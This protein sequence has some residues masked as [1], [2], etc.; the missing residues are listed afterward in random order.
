MTSA[1]VQ[2]SPAPRVLAGALSAALL[3]HVALLAVMSPAL[4]R[5]VEGSA[6]VEPLARIAVVP[7]TETESAVQ[8]VS[9]PP[10][11]DERVPETASFADRFAR[12]VE[13]QTVNRDDVLVARAAPDRSVEAAAAGAAPSRPAAVLVPASR[14]LGGAPSSVQTPGALAPAA[15]E[16]GPREAEPGQTGA[17]AEAAARRPLLALGE[18]NAMNPA[19]APAVRRN[20]HLELDEGD[21]T[22]LNSY[23]SSYW[24][25]FNRVQNQVAAEWEPNAVLRMNDPNGER[26]GAQ[27]RYTLLSVTLNA[28]GTLRH[29]LVRRSSSLDFLDAEAVRAMEAAAPFANVPAGL[30]N[31][32]GQATFTFGF[33]LDAG[34]RSRIRRMN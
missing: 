24:S 14:T 13:R 6:D 1:S 25:F 17:D 8:V 29:A 9:L 18:F 26:Y 10:P 27:D 31:E 20:D 11:E 2:P 33:F 3:L 32:Q 7:D 15:A 23:R 30:V 34:G 16:P 21:R 5:V 4:R 19:A 12:S 22:L 28:D